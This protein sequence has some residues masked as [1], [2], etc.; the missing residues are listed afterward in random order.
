MNRLKKIL[1]IIM[2]IGLMIPA[3]SLPVAQAEGEESNNEADAQD[4]YIASKDEVVYATLRPSGNQKEIYVVNM[5]DIT[6]AG[7]VEDYGNYTSIKNLTDLSDMTQ[8]E[9]KITVD[10]REGK[11]YYQG[12]MEK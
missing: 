12:N 4:G 9:D 10:E 11:L 8:T 6:E 7:V 2:I 3:G 5:L 1:P